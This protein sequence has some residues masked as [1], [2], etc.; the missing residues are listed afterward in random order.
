MQAWPML[1]L[2]K[3]LDDHAEDEG[4][5]RLRL[6]TMVLLKRGRKIKGWSKAMTFNELGN[7]I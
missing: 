2:R 6:H 4:D 3:T 7:R 1:S 5:F